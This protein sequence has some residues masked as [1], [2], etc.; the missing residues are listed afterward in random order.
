MKAGW[1]V[2]VLSPPTPGGVGV[3][4]RKEERRE[5]VPKQ[6]GWVLKCKFENICVSFSGPDVMSHQEEENLQTHKELSVLLT[7]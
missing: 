4:Q 3:K 2:G 1:G 5:V 6:F 7:L